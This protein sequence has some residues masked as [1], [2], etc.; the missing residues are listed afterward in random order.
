MVDEIR[1]AEKALGRVHYGI[2]ESEEAS[3]RFRRSLFV[4]E[5]IKAGEM[6]TGKN[7]RSIR[8]GQRFTHAA[9]SSK[10]WA[11]EPFATARAAR[12]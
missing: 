3:R 7:I 4:V 1:I 9:S 6:F 10:C 5:N 11:D 12:H 2:S 8:A